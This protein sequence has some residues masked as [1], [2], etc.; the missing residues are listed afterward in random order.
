MKKKK[1]HIEE[2]NLFKTYFYDSIDVIKE[3]K[4]AK[5]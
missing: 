3:G 2:D 1:L 5:L 4:Y